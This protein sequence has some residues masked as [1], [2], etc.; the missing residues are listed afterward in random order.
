MIRNNFM[1]AA[2]AAALAASAGSAFAYLPT[3]NADAD[4]VIYWA[5]ASAS[6][7]SAQDAI[8]DFVCDAGAGPINVMSRSSN[9]A[10]A[11]NATA[12]K[13][14]AL[15]TGRVMVIKRDSGGSAV[16]VGPLQQGVSLNF[17]L[18]STGAGGTCLGADVA[19]QSSNGTPYSERSCTSGNFAHVPDI[20]SSDIEPAMFTGANA[21]VLNTSDGPGVPANGT[22]FPFDPNGAAFA[23]TATLGD[24]VFNTPVTTELYKALQAAQFAANSPCYPSAGNGAYSAI[25][26]V[27]QDDPATAV[28]EAISAPRGDT[29]QCMPSLSREEIASIFTGQVKNWEEFKVLNTATNTTIDLRTAANNAGLVLPPL[30]G[31]ATP[32]QVCRRVNGSGTQAQFNAEHLGVNCA[33]G[34]VGP[35]GATTLTLPFVAENSS[36]TNV[37]QCL[38][39]FNNGTN[40]STKNAGLVKR[41]AIGIRSTEASSSSSTTSPFWNFGYRYIKIDGVAPTIENVHRGEY[42]N[43][44]TQN[45]Q[46]APTANAD[47]LAVFDI[48]ANNAFTVAGLKNL[49]NDCKHGF[50]RG[51]WLGTPKSA[52]A[53]PQVFD[54]DLFAAAPV[55][56]F[57]RAPNGKPLNTCQPAVRSEFSTHFIGAP[58]PVFP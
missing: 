58:A 39:D 17:M 23:K 26:Q 4:K 38:D 2:I 5:G 55:N 34:V 48:I 42:W 22:P 50:G 21:P 14:P 47:T 1:Q 19:K 45:L 27:N 36:A 16:G 31:S 15:G 33:S 28:N 35:K 40:V 46:A 44:A 49:N 30:R 20:G 8:I 18:V 24:L 11:C 53:S 6:T 13:T 54:V 10:V 37:E 56:N 12:A 9:W 29:E 41:W 52:G 7:Q 57:T 25:V 43:F 3:S 51:C 32:V